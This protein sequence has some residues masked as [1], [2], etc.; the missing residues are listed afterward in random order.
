[1]SSQNEM[2]V[3]LEA[4]IHWMCTCGKSGNYPLCDGSHKGTGK[5]P[6]KLALEKKT[7]MTVKRP[8]GGEG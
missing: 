1:M 7:T 5:G 3:T 2:E 8:D 4:G 6:E